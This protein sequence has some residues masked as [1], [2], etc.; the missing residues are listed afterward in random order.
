M[1][2]RQLRTFVSIAETGSFQAAAEAVSLTPSAV[3]QQIQALETEVGRALFDRR[4]RPPSLNTQGLQLLDAA[5]S[6]LRLASNAL[7]VIGGRRVATTLSLGSAR[8]SA[9]DLLPPALLAVRRRFPEL[10]ISIR[11]ARSDE[12]LFD[13]LAG[14]LDAAMVPELTNV[15]EALRW[16]AFLREP[17][18]V[19]APPGTQRAPAAHL[20][21]AHPFIRYRRNVPL[22]HLI[23][24]QMATMG[25]QPRAPMEM[26]S[27]SAIVS[28]V[29]AGLGASVV[30][31]LSL[32]DG[33]ARTVLAVPF[34]TPPVRRRFGLIERA[35]HPRRDLVALLHDELVRQ[36]GRLG[37]RRGEPHRRHGT[38]RAPAPQRRT[39]T[40]E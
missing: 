14:R 23:D 37:A 30:P 24:A 4:T 35:E 19:I 21:T 6:M 12:L 26:D 34:G 17:L 36:A 8:T 13:V 16:R 11:S 7:D 25:V 22:A 40:N 28:C 10:E 33:P 20:L 27:M 1:D 29:S 2:L 3:S 31:R 15:P 32:P 9:F 5:R 38:G 18:L 39:P